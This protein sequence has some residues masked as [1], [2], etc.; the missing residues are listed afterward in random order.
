VL[1]RIRIENYRCL[2]GFAWKPAAFNLILGPNGTGKSSLLDVLHAIYRLV[3]G[4]ATVEELF[5]VESRN[6]DE[7]QRP[8][9]FLLQAT[10]GGTEYT[11][12][13]EIQHERRGRPRIAQEEIQR[14]GR[15]LYRFDGDQAR[16]L[17]PDE[18]AG[19]AFP[20]DGRHSPLATLPAGENVTPLAPFLEWLRRL[21]VVRPVPQ[22]MRA[23]VKGETPWLQPDLSNFAAWFRDLL[24][25]EPGIGTRIVKSLRA[26]LPGFEGYA[27]SRETARTKTL[28]FT[29]KSRRRRIG[30]RPYQ[31][32]AGFALDELSDGQRMLVAHYALLHH[33]VGNGHTLGIDEP[34]NF[35]ALNEIQPWMDE[36]RDVAGRE[37]GQVFLVSHHP[38][39]I[40]LYATKYGHWFERKGTGPVRVRPIAIRPGDEG[41]PVSDLVA[42]GW[43][44][45]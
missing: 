29:F 33:V 11:Y 34:D 36:L 30:P 26:V 18:D 39:L 23:D 16:L 15:P 13:L 32:P 37:G 5:P 10:V 40:D 6:R 12:A 27:F 7:P 14:E 42:R 28:R 8:Q 24:E 4:W 41:I 3:S 44:V 20:F 31:G 2:L 35:V 21:W 43:I 9:R 25:E 22:L 1:T 19:A 45:G 38:R 17:V